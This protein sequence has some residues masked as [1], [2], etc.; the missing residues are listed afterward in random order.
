MSEIIIDKL[1]LGDISDSANKEF[2][3]ENILTVICCA[4]EL[5][6]PHTHVKHLEHIE[7]YKFDIA[8]GHDIYKYFDIVT[9]LI[10]SKKRVLI[11]C[12]EGI[13]RSASI[14]IAYLM[15]YL[16]MS[17]E[18]SFNYVKEIRNEIN[19]NINNIKKLKNYIK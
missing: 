17:Y 18:E 5:F 11:H 7:F 4:S 6:S 10:H 14:V 13:N 9:E 1:W 8:E 19:P 15:R 2:L 12:Y 3:D 16:H